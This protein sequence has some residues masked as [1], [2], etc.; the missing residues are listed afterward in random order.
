MKQRV[1]RNYPGVTLSVVQFYSF[2]SYFFQLLRKSL[3]QSLF[4]RF[5]EFPGIDI[6]TRLGTNYKNVNKKYLTGK[7]V[8][9]PFLYAI[10]L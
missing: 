3:H 1:G 7:K 10:F 6:V 9:G 4:S 8:F 2:Y 5:S